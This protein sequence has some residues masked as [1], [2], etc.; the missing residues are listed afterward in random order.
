MKPVIGI[1]GSEENERFTLASGYVRSIEAAGGCA[2][3][4]IGSL[5][6][7][8]LEKMDGFVLTGGGDIDPIHFGEAPAVGL[9]EVN[10]AR[11]ERE[12]VLLKKLTHL[13]KPVLGICKGMQMLNVASGGTIH[14]D[15]YSIPNNTFL[16]HNAK[17]PRHEAHHQVNVISGSFLEKWTGASV[18]SVNS[19]HH[20][21]VHRVGDGMRVSATSSD[22]VVEAIEHSVFPW[23]GV[24]WHP[25]TMA[26]SPHAHQL[27][28]GF[29]AQTKELSYDSH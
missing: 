13:R 29:I 10:G 24:Q 4:L 28:N 25:E 11:D 27:F 26:T 18:L 1:V 7:A 15:L 9:G 20:Q 16:Q 22:G 3:Y 21:A 6:E 12:L 8:I 19:F 2:V 14:Q 5:D 23:Y 17:R